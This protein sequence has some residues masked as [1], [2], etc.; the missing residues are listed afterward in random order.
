MFCRPHGGALC[1]MIFTL[2]S[3]STYPAHS[4]SNN[5][6]AGFGGRWEGRG[7]V[8]LT[9]GSREALRCKAV[10]GVG[11]DGNALSVDVN[12]ASDSYRMHIVSSV[13]ADRG[14]FSGSWQ[15][16]TRQVQGSVTGLLP[17]PGVMQANFDALGGGIQLGARMDGR[18]Q[19]ITIKSQ[20]TDIEGVDIIL[21]RS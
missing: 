5:T 8:S 11:G 20:G 7:T 13:V 12:C 18:H 2:I 1:V 19:A 9:D 15:E 4:R 16:T 6:F 21:K 3:A 14:R 10:Y 17:E